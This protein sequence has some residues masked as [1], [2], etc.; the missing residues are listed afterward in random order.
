MF[1]HNFD[2]LIA[3]SL[4]ARDEIAFEPVLYPSAVADMG[5]PKFAADN[6]FINSH[7]YLAFEL[8][9]F[10]ETLHAKTG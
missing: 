8:K 9:K 4:S 6:H 1:Q 5:E 2:E 7:C 10:C 3:S